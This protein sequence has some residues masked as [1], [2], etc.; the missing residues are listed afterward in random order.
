MNQKVAAVRTEQWRQMV[1]DCINRDPKITKLQWCEENGIKIRSLMYWQRKFQLEAL[2]KIENNDTIL[3]VRSSG[4]N[5]PAFVDMTTQME[6][7]QGKQ[8]TDSLG[9]DTMA[10]APELVIHAGSY[11]IYVNSSVREATLETVMRVISRA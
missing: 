10:S 4:A 1:Y 5:T 11:K 3:P 7:L 8:R 6:K 9:P 2:D